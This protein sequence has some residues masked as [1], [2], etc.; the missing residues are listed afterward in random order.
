MMHL[1]RIL[2]DY[3]KQLKHKRNGINLIESWNF[4]LFIDL[5]TKKIFK[6]YFFYNKIEREQN[7]R[8]IL[9]LL[10]F[11][12]NLMKR[13]LYWDDYYISILIHSNERKTK[14]Y[15]TF[16][17]KIIGFEFNEEFIFCQIE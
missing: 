10:L 3:K 8:L 13:R 17:D 11:R 7:Q 16:S 5:N 12:K 1:D 9:I 4:N 14:K 2:A 6:I 15:E